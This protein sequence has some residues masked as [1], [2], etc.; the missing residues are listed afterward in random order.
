MAIADGFQRHYRGID[1][2]FGSG[3]D[4]ILLKAAVIDKD[5]IPLPYLYESHCT[6]I[7]E[8]PETIEHSSRYCLYVKDSRATKVIGNKSSESL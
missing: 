8:V 5:S 6:P 4:N 2:N 7:D 1:L 3:P